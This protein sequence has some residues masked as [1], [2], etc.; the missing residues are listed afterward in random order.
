[1]LHS[2]S[3]FSSANEDYFLYLVVLFQGELD[4][5]KTGYFLRP[6]VEKVEELG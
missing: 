4:E 3:L 6:H 1:M 5:A 2:Y